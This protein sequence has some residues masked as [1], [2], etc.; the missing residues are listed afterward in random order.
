MDPSD[1]KTRRTG[2]GEWRL[3]APA[4]QLVCR[5][6]PG[7]PVGLRTSALYLPRTTF[8]Y[9]RRAQS[10][11]NGLRSRYGARS[12]GRPP[13][14]RPI[15]LRDLALRDIPTAFGAYSGLSWQR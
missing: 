15:R 6:R 1:S 13:Q 7:N 4:N 14:T 5:D 12:V 2:M 11:G 8:Q 10:P 3:G 9:R